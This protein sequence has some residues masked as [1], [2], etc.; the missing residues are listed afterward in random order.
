MNYKIPRRTGS[1]RENSPHARHSSSAVMAFED[2]ETIR[3]PRGEARCKSPFQTCQL[4]VFFEP[5]RYR[6]VKIA[7]SC[8]EVVLQTMKNYKAHYSLSYF[9]PLLQGNSLTSSIFCIEE[10]EQCYNRVS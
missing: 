8:S 4:S 10:E 5:V 2:D 9:R 6:M 3:T 1:L 7:C